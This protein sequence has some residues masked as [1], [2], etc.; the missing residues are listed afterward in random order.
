MT[1]KDYNAVAAIINNAY[2][3]DDATDDSLVD[4]ATKLADLFVTDNES[5]D[6]QRFFAAC[7]S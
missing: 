3:V 6:R 2:D 1:R 5:F 7:F 4:I